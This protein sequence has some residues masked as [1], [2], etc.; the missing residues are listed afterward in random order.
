MEPLELGSG[1]EAVKVPV[2]DDDPE[3]GVLCTVAGWGSTQVSTTGASVN[4]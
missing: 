2:Q 4:K 3:V 1:F